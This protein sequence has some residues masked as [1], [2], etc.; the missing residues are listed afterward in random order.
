MTDRPPTYE[1]EVLSVLAYE[2]ST[3]DHA[4]SER[5]IKRR[6]RDKKL[7]TYDQRRIEALR[8]LK[9]DLIKELGRNVRSR[10]YAGS[11]GKYSNMK[12]WDYNALLEYMKEQHSQVPAT[13]IEG[14][15]SYAIYLYYL[16]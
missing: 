7:G 11:H 6:L 1:G 15:L 10:F 13:A 9:S 16:R 5:K 4:E 12:D 2:F 3:S 14:F 8:L